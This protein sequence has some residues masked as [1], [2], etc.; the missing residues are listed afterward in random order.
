[1]SPIRLS[2]SHLPLRSI[3]GQPNLIRVN[4]G[5]HLFGLWCSILRGG[6]HVT[7]V[8][9]FDYSFEEDDLSLEIAFD[10]FGTVKSVKK[11]TFV[12]NPNVFNGTGLINIV[13]SRV[14]PRFLMADGYLCRLSYRGQPLVCNLCAVQG[15]KSAN[16][17][18][19]DK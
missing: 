12:S 6:P 14:L 5:K 17:P 9:D 3:S 13:L 15:H 8:H 16:C 7:C 4:S 2:V 18:N 11:Q 1:M 19:E 10:T